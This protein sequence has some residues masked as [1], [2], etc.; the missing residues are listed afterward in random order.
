MS[1]GLFPDLWFCIYY[2]LVNPSLSTLHI[3][4][5]LKVKNQKLFHLNQD[6][7]EE[8]DIHDICVTNGLEHEEKLTPPSPHCFLLIFIYCSWTETHYETTIPSEITVK[9]KQNK[10]RHLRW[11]YNYSDTMFFLNNN[12]YLKHSTKTSGV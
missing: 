6:F 11:E 1:Q 10:N 8:L 2:I 3:K 5:Y 9:Q 12:I 4:E 7:N